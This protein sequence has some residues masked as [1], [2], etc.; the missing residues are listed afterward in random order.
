MR[1]YT[2]TIVSCIAVAALAIALVGGAGGT[3]YAAADQA[4][5]DRAGHAL[6]LPDGDAEAQTRRPAR[7][8][9]RRNESS[10]PRARTADAKPRSTPRAQPRQTVQPRRTGHRRRS[11]ARAPAPRRHAGAHRTARGDDRAGPGT[12]RGRRR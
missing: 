4:A 9:P 8:R 1:R 10:R 7:E 6:G 5:R 3:E 11:P 2:L 12:A